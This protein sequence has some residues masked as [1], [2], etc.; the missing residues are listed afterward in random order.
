[1]TASQVARSNG[2]AESLGVVGSRWPVLPLKYSLEY[3][4]GPGIM[5]AD[6]ATQGVPL[7]RISC[8]A[9]RF[10]TLDGCDYLSPEL[11]ESRW[12]HFRVKDGDLLISASASTG[13]CAEVRTDTVGAVPYTGVIIM[14]P[15]TTNTDRGYARWFLLSELFARQVAL[16]QAGS[17]IQHFGPSHLG[18]MFSPIPPPAQQHAIGAYLDRE[19]GRIDALIGAK[20][21]S[22]DFL[23]EK[24]RALIAAAVTRGL[25]STA[26]MHDSGVPWLGRVPAH[27]KATRLKFVARVQTGI[28]LGKDVGTRAVRD[29]PYLRVANVQDG[30]LDLSE[31]KT[32]A[33][34]EQ[35]ASLSLLRAGD[36]LMNEG[37]DADKLGRGAIWSGEIEPCV[38]QNHVFAVRPY[39]VSSEWLNAWTSSDPAKA[40]F[41][42]RAKQST[43]LAS[44]SATNLMEMPLLCPPAEEQG[45]IVDYITRETSKID[46]VRAATERTIVLL[47]ERRAALISAAVTGQIDVE[48]A[49]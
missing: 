42:S 46:D 4:E 12:P 30:F 36:V 25:R 22:L 35:E 20:R 5:A 7:L 14:R 28:A 33:I 2:R 39:G 49:A 41:E 45:K 23:A 24:R 38:H 6:F 40:Y 3:V 31:V 19:V 27:W 9:G 15:R 21:Q 48:A 32:M 17:A 29:F 18:L 37:G 10:A 11:V 34:S 26:S 44:I 1:M 47:M 43:N 13:L 8:L 16:L